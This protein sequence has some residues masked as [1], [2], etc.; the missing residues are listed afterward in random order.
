MYKRQ[1]QDNLQNLGFTGLWVANATLQKC[2]RLD[3]GNRYLV[4]LAT[5]PQNPDTAY[6]R[7][8]TDRTLYT[9]LWR[10]NKKSLT[11]SEAEGNPGRV[12]A[13]HLDQ[14][15][16]VRL[17][18]VA[19]N[20][21]STSYLYRPPG[22]KSW[23]SLALPNLSEPVTFDASG[24]AVLV[25]FQGPEGRLQLQGFDLATKQF[26]GAPIADAVYDISPAV[27]HDPKT[28]VPVGLIYNTAKPAFLWL[29]G[30]Y[31]QIH[32]TLQQSFPNATVLTRGIMESGEV[33]F[34]VSSDVLPQVLYRYSAQ[35]REIHP[36]I[37][38]QPEAAALKWAPVQPVSF[39]TRDGQTVYAYLTLPLGRRPDQ[40][41]P[42]VALS[43]GGPEVRDDWGFDPEV[44]FLAGLGYGVLQ[45]N[46]RGSIG[47]GHAYALKN[48]IEVCEKS[49]DDVVDGIRWT[50][51]EGYV[52]PARIAAYGGSYGGYISLGIATR[53]PDLLAASVG[54][55]G[56]YDWE[57]QW[58]ETR[59]HVADLLR[60][61]ADYY[62]DSKTH[63]ELYRPFNP[64]G[65]AAKVRGP[66]LLLH[67]GSDSTVDI[68][69]TNLMARAL[70]DAGRSVEVIK[71]AEGIHGLPNEE[72]RRTFYTNLA[73]FLLK[74]VPPDAAP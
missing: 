51:A 43:H 38:S 59:K 13:W 69:Q 64:A 21:G 63:G 40:K 39:A 53:Y 18:T 10:L 42:L 5:L 48:S 34:S 45:V 16:Q 73:A 3:L 1:I 7:E 52:D 27:I 12:V 26:S 20:A 50:I 6:L 31:A 66:V 74:N 35:K 41:V 55:A 54:F 8:D 68:N 72:A 32:A 2:S 56:V 62:I 57:S 19:G 9:P 37:S 60:W 67:G 28:G 70:R 17:A 61:R 46:Y 49:V 71:D 44:Q 33:L 4:P 14:A 25:A 30:Q 15:G 23:E 24:Q 22:V 11:V 65:A 36:V 29:N 58:K 47:Y